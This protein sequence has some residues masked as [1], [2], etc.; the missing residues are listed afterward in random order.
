VST[1]F[2]VVLAVAAAIT[3]CIAGWAGLQALGVQERPHAEGAVMAAIPRLDPAPLPPPLPEVRQTVEASAPRRTTR[4]VGSV[5]LALHGL[6]SDLAAALV[7]RSGW[8]RVPLRVRDL[9]DRPETVV[10]G[11]LPHGEH[12]VDVVV[13]P[14]APPAC[15]LTRVRVAVPATA[16]VELDLRTGSLRVTVHGPAGAGLARVPVRLERRDDPAWLPP[17]PSADG[18]GGPITAADGSV[19]FSPLGVGCYRVHALAEGAL[20]AEARVPQQDAVTLT[21]P[22]AR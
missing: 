4:D 8:S 5:A 21:V 12:L 6:P 3:A 16:A 19:T 10:L 14:A 15:Y 13:D 18:F 11:G 2:R 1:L 9:G 7:V 22:A 17:T 20:P